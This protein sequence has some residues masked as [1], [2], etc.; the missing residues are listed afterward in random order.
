MIFNWNES[1]IQQKMVYFNFT[2]NNKN[3]LFST[4]NNE[5]LLIN[6]TKDWHKTY[7]LNYKDKSNLYETDT[8]LLKCSI[9]IANKEI[10]IEVKNNA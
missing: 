3:W 8:T 7:F 10:N 2:Y 1:H 5:V 4:L 6:T 9:S